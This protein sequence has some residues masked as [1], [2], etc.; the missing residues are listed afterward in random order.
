MVLRTFFDLPREI[1]DQIYRYVFECDAVSPCA[2]TSNNRPRKRLVFNRTVRRG[3]RFL[4]SYCPNDVL[5]L[6]LVNRQISTEAALSFYGNTSFSGTLDD[7]Y[8]FL[9]GIGP[10]R[11]NMVRTINLPPQL[12]SAEKAAHLR[13]Y[14]LL[15]T[16]QSLRRVQISFSTPDMSIVRK[17]LLNTG[18]CRLMGIVDFVL[19]NFFESKMVDQNF[20][21]G[22][23][24]I[25][26]GEWRY[27]YYKDERKPV[28]ESRR[29]ILA[30]HSGS[31]QH[32]VRGP[33]FEVSLFRSLGTNKINSGVLPND[34][35]GVVEFY[36]D[37]PTG[38]SPLEWDWDEWDRYDDQ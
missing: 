33:H 14:N 18:V 31:R 16:L 26:R 37:L 3:Q 23:P 6:L 35:M 38:R 11:R 8:F 24:Y 29:N 9:K 22:C 36:G 13:L 5:A 7:M 21:M 4:P 20:N 2:K 1:R 27:T 34:L 15:L 32:W 30:V 17:A 25:F 12:Y 28:E 10:Q 19:Y